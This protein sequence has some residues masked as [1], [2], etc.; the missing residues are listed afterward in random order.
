MIVSIKSQVNRFT[1]CGFVG[2]NRAVRYE[3]ILAFAKLVSN[4]LCFSVLAIRTPIRY[5]YLYLGQNLA[6]LPKYSGSDVS[7]TSIQMTRF[8]LGFNKCVSKL[9]DVELDDVLFG[10]L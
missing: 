4:L 7:E 2:D 9:R 10:V 5:A 8:H 6:F 1:D 3:D